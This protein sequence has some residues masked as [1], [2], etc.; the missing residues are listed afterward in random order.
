MGENRFNRCLSLNFCY[1][2]NFEN[3]NTVFLSIVLTLAVSTVRAADPEIAQDLAALKSLSPAAATTSETQQAWRRISQADV[4]MLP[5]ILASL[6]DAGPA[7][8]N[9][10][11]SAVDAIVQRGA[12]QSL[13]TKELE[14]FLFD[15]K[16]APRARRLAYEIIAAADKTAPERILINMLDDP[17]VEMRRDAVGVLLKTADEL[18]AIKPIDTAATVHFY[19]RA[20]KSARDQDQIDRC[21]ERLRQFGETVDVPRH[22]GFVMSWRVI[23]PFDNR[24]KKGLLAVYPPEEKLDFS[25][26][27]P[28]LFDAAGAKIDGAASAEKLEWRPYT[29]TDDFGH[30]DLNKAIGKHM[31]A[32]GYAAAEFSSDQDRDV[33]VR[34]GTE[35]A[36]RLWVNAKLLQTSEVYHSFSGM[37]QFVVDVHWNK[38]RNAILMKVCQNDQKD[39]WAQGWQFQLRVCDRTG[40]A[41]LSNEPAAG[42]E[43]KQK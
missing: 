11:R 39:D 34:I 42:I 41:I 31:N 16:H 23:G 1:P 4:A 17:S 38:G 13:P 30:I 29:S 26:H 21:V 7:A 12:G 22:Y 10:I 15:T 19:E 33:Q 25:A 24:D 36:F 37:D 8:A 9:S 40:T 32:A 27:Y 20:F 43:P 28:A 6:D 3:C 14:R 5:K 2:M 35:N 18:A